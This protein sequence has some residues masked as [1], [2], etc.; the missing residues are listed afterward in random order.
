MDK[1]PTG[2]DPHPPRLAVDADGY[3]WRVSGHG[4]R[5]SMSPVT[6]GPAILSDNGPVPTPVT[7]YSPA[8]TASQEGEAVSGAE[9]IAAERQRQIEAEGW[10]PE[11]DDGHATGD[12]AEAAAAYTLNDVTLFPWPDWWKPG[13]DPVRRLVKAGALI[14]AEI[15][16]LSRAAGVLRQRQS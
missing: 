11:H 10:T 7:F 1:R 2:F 3:V 6:S 8:N 9:L 14:A 13:T 4:E 15:D 5:M 16:R 12:L